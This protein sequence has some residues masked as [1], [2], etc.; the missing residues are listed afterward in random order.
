MYLITSQT[1][2][3]IVLFF[4]CLFLPLL[5]FVSSPTSLFAETTF[6]FVDKDG[7]LL[8]D[9]PAD[10][11]EFSDPDVLYYTISPEGGRKYDKP[12]SPRHERIIATI[13]KKTGKKVEW[14]SVASSVE[15]IQLMRDGKLHI[16]GFSTGTT[17][18]AV[19]LA[20]FIPF[21]VKTDRYKKNEMFGYHL[22]VIVNSNS[23]Y[24]SL[25]DLQGKVIAH[26]SATSNSGNIAPRALL[27]EF[28]L[29]PDSTYQVVYSG[30]HKKSILGVVD[31]TYP[32][33][34]VAS[35]TLK[36]MISDGKV[37]AEDIRILYA[38]PKFPTLSMGYVYN[39]NPELIRQIK[40]IFF[41]YTRTPLPEE[42]EKVKGYMPLSYKRDWEII[43]HIAEFSGYS[44]TEEGLT[45]MLAKKKK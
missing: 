31:G 16:A 8:C 7:D 26:T 40:K 11:K 33:A 30:K 25:Y 17:G 39:L 42:T 22:Q 10:P 15:E 21:A 28:G 6:T 37:A 29:I 2:P 36:R 44:Y 19:N 43:R 3:R 24:Q 5:F 13:A 4:I 35:S 32:A 45:K 20:G 23:P 18:F 1:R 27:P 41:D 14:L 38:S 12:N 34:A 9:S